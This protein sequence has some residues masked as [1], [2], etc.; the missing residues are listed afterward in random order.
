MGR[1]EFP[2]LCIATG[3]E[4][5]LARE[6]ARKKLT[7]K[8][9]KGS[10]KEH[11]GNSGKTSCPLRFGFIFGRVDGRGRPSLQDL[12]VGA[13]CGLGLGGRGHRDFLVFVL[14]LVELVVNAALGE[15]L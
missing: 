2:G 6:S 4:F 5:L 7:T 9:T 3:C 11:K 12:V 1:R 13:D 10:T 8:D 15:Q 14:Q